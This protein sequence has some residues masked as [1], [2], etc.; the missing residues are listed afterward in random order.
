MKQKIFLLLVLLLSTGSY[1]NDVENL[2]NEYLQALKEQNYKKLASLMDTDAIKPLHDMFIALATKAEENGKFDE[3]RI[4]PLSK[5]KNAAKLESANIQEFYANLMQ[6]GL[7]QDPETLEMF[8]EA[9]FKYIGVV[10]ETKQNGYAVY[11]LKLDID[12][13]ELEVADLLPI[14]TRNGKVT[15]SMTIEMEALA[16]AFENELAKGI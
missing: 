5:Y 11:K 2:T 9:D 8:S 3:I 10:Y 1:A 12:G 16:T 15:A 6:M 4:G 13:Y 7:E 14:S